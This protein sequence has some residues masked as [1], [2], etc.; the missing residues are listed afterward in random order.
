LIYDAEPIPLSEDAIRNSE[1]YKRILT[2]E[3]AAAALMDDDNSDEDRDSK[4]ESASMALLAMS[5]IGTKRLGSGGLGMVGQSGTGIGGRAGGEELVDP[6]AIAARDRES[7]TKVTNFLQR[8]RNS[9]T[10]NN[11]LSR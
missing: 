1:L 11:R 4:E 6:A 3:A 5:Q 8:V 9:H 7:R 10:A 2:A